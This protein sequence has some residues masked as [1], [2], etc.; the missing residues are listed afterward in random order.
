M[1]NNAIQ[2]LNE[3]LQQR[4]N[5]NDPIS[6]RIE[7]R[8][9]DLRNAN[10]QDANL[11]GANLRRANLEGANL[12]GANLRRANL[13]DANLV[14]AVLTNADVTHAFLR[15][16][17]L[18]GAIL[19]GSNFSFAKLAR[20]HLNDANLSRAILSNAN[21]E[22]SRLEGANLSDAILDR[23]ILDSA[24]LT[25]AVLTNANV[26]HAILRNANL[27]GAILIGTN[28]SFAVLV[29]SHFH[30]ANLSRAILSNANLTRSQLVFTNLTRANLDG[31][32]FT[33]AHIDRCFFNGANV[34]NAIDLIIDDDMHPQPNRVVNNQPNRVVNNQP[35][36]LAYEIHD[37]FIRFQP[38]IPEFLSIINQPDKEVSDI[39]SYINEIF[40]SNITQ[41]FP[42]DN[43]KIEDF[44][45][46]FNK[47]NGDIEQRYKDL[48]ERYKD[49][50]VKSLDFAFSQDH[51]FKEEYIKA[52]LDETCHAYIGANGTSC[53][54][55]IIERFTMCIGSVV[56]ILCVDGCENEIY[57]TL[58]N[59]FNPKFD[60]DKTSTEWWETMALTDEVKKM[61]KQE[62]KTHFKNYLR[63]KAEELNNY[64]DFMAGEITRYANNI[65]YS[66]EN[67]ALGGSSR[68]TRNPKKS[69]K[70]RR[71]K[72]R[73][74][75][76][77][78]KS[79][80]YKR[81]KK[82]MKSKKIL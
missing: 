24:N 10:L 68:K 30:H 5:S 37:A 65:D 45:K 4:R 64:N 82:F 78:I 40:T 55:G 47:I 54:P 9:A 49:L 16:A 11:E 56:Q 44:N 46:V 69:R 31:A 66:F 23:A 7:F 2:R 52:F 21:L 12:E 34:E 73:K 76:K 80:S 22:L 19:I 71:I 53:I 79:T 36:G 18:D 43:S 35:R 17:Q 50:I 51:H 77:T 70:I 63:E 33:N 72:S 1:E 32:I 25:N 14:N 29:G 48:I 81:S 60:I 13:E 59:L 27:Q 61:T 20:S 28:F 62:R 57:Q 58:N 39:Y 6:I 67:L 15:Y 8:N 42:G 3:L 75:K 26:T 38:K 74:F 41:L